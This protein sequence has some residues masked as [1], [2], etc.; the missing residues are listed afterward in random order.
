MGSA[1]GQQVIAAETLASASFIRSRREIGR[2]LYLVSAGGSVA[3]RV[4]SEEKRQAVR[5]D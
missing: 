2:F 4:S 5:T 3:N 1:G